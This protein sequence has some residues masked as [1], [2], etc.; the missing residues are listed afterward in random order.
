MRRTLRRKELRLIVPLGD[1]TIYEMGR[2]GEFPRRVNLT[3]RCVV[4]D[5]AEVEA[6]ID[7]R[8]KDSEAR[9]A[10]VAPSPDVRV[11]M[12]RPVKLHPQIDRA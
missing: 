7:Q 12:A 2:R 1:T 10:S 9:L 5:F 4:W 6:W 11:R 8:R 3:P